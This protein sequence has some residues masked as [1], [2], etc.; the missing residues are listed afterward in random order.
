M[1]PL[2]L[3]AL[4]G[5]S[6][7][8]RYLLDPNGDPPDDPDAYTTADRYD[9]LYEHLLSGYRASEGGP[10]TFARRVSAAGRADPGPVSIHESL[11]LVSPVELLG[12]ERFAVA[13]ALRG[14]PAPDTVLDLGC[15][16]GVALG[17]LAATFPD[18]RIVGGERSEAGVELA[19][20]LHADC[21]RIAVER[22]DFEGPWELL[23]RASGATLVFT[24]GVL[25]TLPDLE[26]VVDRLAAHAAG[27]SLVGGVHLE[28]VDEHPE[29]TL[30]LLRRRYDRVRGYD[31][32]AL[33]AL[34]A[35][36][37][38]VVD[39]VAYDAM[40]ANPL[41]PQTAVRWRAVPDAD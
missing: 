26:T 35:D 11:Y 31:G 28:Q 22:F 3:D 14:V 5:H 1:R 8:T 19:R 30:G 4:P 12:L 38:V 13:S 7:W 27:G 17:P 6:E 32:S 2:A 40:G 15:G 24:R 36:D 25:T 33:A 9:A 23:E 18:A 10:E 20:E 37:R 34:R 39:R 29:T 16:W 21:D 41:H